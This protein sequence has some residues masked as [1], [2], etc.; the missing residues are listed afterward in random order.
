MKEATNQDWTEGSSSPTS[1]RSSLAL[2]ISFLGLACLIL[3]V[4][5]FRNITDLLMVLVMIGIAFFFGMARVTVGKF[6]YFEIFFPFSVLYLIYFGWSAIYLK[7]NIDLMQHR[8]LLPWLTPALGL[9]LVGYVAMTAGYTTLTRKVRPSKFSKLVPTGI[10]FLLVAGGIGFIGQLAESL[11]ARQWI[12]V[13]QVSGFLS[14]GQQIAPIFFFAWYVLWYMV[15]S[16]KLSRLER[17][18]LLSL[19]IPAALMV[20]YLK[21]GG[22]EMAI[23]TLGMPAIAYWYVHRKPP[24]KSILAVMLVGL[25]VIFPIY[26]TYRNQSDRLDNVRR[27][28]QTINVA[29]YW[30]TK[31]FMDNSVRAFL[32]R[33]G[34]ITSVAVVLRD[35]PDLVPYSNGK[36]LVLAP[37]G[38]FIPRVLWPGKPVIKVG[39]EF[40]LTFRM[41]NA[42][43]RNT[44]IAPSLVGEYYWNFGLPGVVIG[45]FLTGGVYRFIYRKFGE[46]R[47]FTPVSSGVYM[48]LFMSLIHFEGSFAAQLGGAVKSFVVLYLLIIVSR[49]FNLL[50]VPESATTGRSSGN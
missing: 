2:A 32:Q 46:P 43:D 26:N 35:V 28:S 23:V 1:Q 25:F 11:Q 7:Q 8:S 33:M 38:I 9:A 37:I 48:M 30:N 50:A 15:W 3:S 13:R 34:I 45:M 12:S 29:T 47:G 22:K 20:L 27:M 41:V 21:L 36:T 39:R 18:L 40:G 14:I 5:F 6:D 19:F 4:V 49:K 24:W 16:R 10:G 42:V 31:S 44:S 17:Y